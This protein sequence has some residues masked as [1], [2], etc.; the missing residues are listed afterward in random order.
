M[1]GEEVLFDSGGCR[2]AGTFTE[3]AER[4]AAALLLSGSGGSDR[5]SDVRRGGRTLRVGVMRAVAD[6]LERSRVSSLR[7]DK[8]GVGASGGD[9]LRAGM[10]DGRA[11]ARAALGWLAERVPA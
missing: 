6:A 1:S 4:V 7:Y 3:A 8:R 11:D 9:V 10:A 5:D 2:L